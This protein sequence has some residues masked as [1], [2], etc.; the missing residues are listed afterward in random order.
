MTAG[1]LDKNTSAGPV[2]SGGRAA[3]RAVRSAPLDASIRPIKPGMPGGNFNPLKP[4][5]V[6][7]IHDAA[8]E[9]LET[10]GL[11]DAP[12]SGV[13]VLKEAGA[14]YGSDGRVRFP[15]S[16]VEDMLAINQKELVL[17]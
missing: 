12:E 3:R 9:A 5:G 8:L 11:L 17:L 14:I 6:E 13:K 1:E 2:R 15:R 4:E 16:L 10:I 7:R